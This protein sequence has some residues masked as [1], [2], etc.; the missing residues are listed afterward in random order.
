M[1]AITISHARRSSD[2]WA[3]NLRSRRVR[4]ALRM[5]PPTMRIQS[6][7]KNHKSASAVLTC[8]ATMNAR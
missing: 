1:V 5:N 7:R 2:P 6:A 8:R 4:R 3:L